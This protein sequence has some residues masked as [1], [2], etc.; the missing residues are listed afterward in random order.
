MGPEKY[1]KWTKIIAEEF[2]AF[3][4]FSLLMGINHLPGL[5]NYWS[6]D[7]C[8]RYAPVANRNSR[9]G[10]QEI[11]RYL[12]FVDNDTQVPRGEEGHD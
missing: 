6:K 8:L 10:F 1:D 4:S 9:D 7:P 2:K 12:R 5:D 3:L 11:S